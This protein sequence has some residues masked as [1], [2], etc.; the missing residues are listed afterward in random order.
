MSVIGTFLGLILGILV[1]RMVIAVG[2][3][4][5]LMFSRSAGILSFVYAAVLS[6]AFSLCVNLVLRRNLERVDIVESL[7][8]NE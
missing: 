4:D 6:M 5:I 2:E 7:K 8:S 1:H 3:V